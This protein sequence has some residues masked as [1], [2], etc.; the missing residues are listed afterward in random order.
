MPIGGI[1]PPAS[2]RCVF[3]NLRRSLPYR[4][5]G[6]RSCFGGIY[7]LVKSLYLPFVFKDDFEWQ[8]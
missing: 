3:S 4:L 7:Y 6:S 2:A 1:N 5:R 8:Y